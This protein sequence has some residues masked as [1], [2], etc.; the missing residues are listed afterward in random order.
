VDETMDW[1]VSSYVPAGTD[2]ANYRLSPAR[3]EIG[4]YISPVFMVSV[5]LDPLAADGSTYVRA[6]VRAG[7]HVTFRCVLG[8]PHGRFTS[9]GVYQVANQLLEE[10]S[11]FIHSLHGMKPEA[12]SQSSK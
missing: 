8:V 10:V 12:G 4:P 9:G 11:A 7:G 6:L 2:L 3:A 1:F 5:D